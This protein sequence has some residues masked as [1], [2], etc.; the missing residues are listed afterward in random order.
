MS[1][2]PGFS[3]LAL[4][5]LASTALALAASPASAA[6]PLDL[7]AAIEFGASPAAL[8][9]SFDQLCESYQVRQLDP[10]ELP[11]AQDSH[12]QVDCHG[13]D[14]AGRGRLAE[15]VFADDSLAFI[16]ILTDAS[17]E[18]T[19]LAALRAQYGTPSHDTPVFVAFADHNVALRRDVPEFLYY[20]EAI[21]PMYRGWFD[22][23]AAQ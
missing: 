20:G 23:M 12:T 16:W 17:E 6:G 5:A 18:G 11:I 2:L 10:A 22:Q 7:P 8:G 15:F 9:D 14:H 19:H 3:A 13:F 21:A 4:T 1:S